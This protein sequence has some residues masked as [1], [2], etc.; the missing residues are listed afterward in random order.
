MNLLKARVDHGY[1]KK[2]KDFRKYP[3]MDPRKLIKLS[4]SADD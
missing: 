1:V 2:K 3:S 4:L